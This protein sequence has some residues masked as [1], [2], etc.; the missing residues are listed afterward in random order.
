METKINVSQDPFQE[1]G[2]TVAECMEGYIKTKKAQPMLVDVRGAYA[3][4]E[5][6]LVRKEPIK[7]SLEDAR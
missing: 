2:L 5:Q 1:S 4:F 6:G 3:L 7:D